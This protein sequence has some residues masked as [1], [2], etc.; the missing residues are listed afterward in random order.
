[1]E[2]RTHSFQEKF[3]SGSHIP[4]WIDSTSPVS[5][6][7]LNMDKETEVVIVGGGISGVTV[8]YCLSL[9]GKKV[10]LV[11]DGFIGSG[12]TGRT[13]AHLVNALDDRYYELERLFGEENARLIAQS[14]S[15]AIN[16]VER[17]I[18]RENIDCEFERVKGYLFRHPS[19]KEENL[20]KEFE[21]CKKLHLNVEKITLVPG[22]TKVY[23]AIQF[24][25]QGQ[26]HP[27]KYIRALCEAIVRN[28]GEI[29][30]NTHAREIDKTGI[31][32]NENF[33][34][35]AEHIVIATNTPVNNKY[36]MHLKQYAYRTYVIG[37]KIKKDSLPKALWWDTGDFKANSEIAPYHY[38]RT[39][40]LN[41]KYD[42]LIVGG[43]DHATGL[44]D[45]E[46]YKPEESRYDLL[47]AWAREHFP[48]MK[49][50]IYKW[51]GQVM[52]PMDSLAYIGRNP[53]D[54]DNI[55]I[56]TGDS[57]NG[58]THGTI[59][60]LLITDLI[61][62]VENKWEAIY[63]PSRMK[64]F[65][66]GK[67]FFKEFVGGLI[68]YIK[69]KPSH[70]DEIGLKDIRP[71][72]GKIIEFEGEKF[73]AYRDENNIIHFVD[74]ECTHLGCMIKWNNDEK[75]WDC[76]CHGSR[77]THEGEV[78]NGPANKP[79][80]YYSQNKIVLHNL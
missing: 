12:E 39:Q 11:E 77:F 47:E 75:S 24:N 69:T 9:T 66:A 28:G 70:V 54:N 49:N 40:A 72:E 5:Y 46:P 30:T 68:N 61:N 63:S 55:Y 50:I 44:A 34:I 35:K 52:E 76:P 71:N 45:A 19:D 31:V 79:L 37:A 62:K 29:Y 43:E 53:M 21:T 57:G 38:V 67:T 59:A 80:P 3:T 27:L 64:L 78:L 56:V 18:R 15:E 42:L 17:T 2:K 26:F 20:E 33:K 65:K 1:M 48:A 22:I 8:A 25:G 10:I 6:G 16:F 60:G 51:S 13:T 41:D 73:G 14:H 7:K 32:T 4:Y 23:E 58:M 36:V 74:A